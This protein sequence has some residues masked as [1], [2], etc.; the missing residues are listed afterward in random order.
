M[1]ISSSTRRSRLLLFFIC[2]LP[3]INHTSATDFMELDEVKPGMRGVGRTVFSGTKIED[4]DVEV[5]SILRN[6]SPGRNLILVRL[7]GKVVDHAGV[8]EGM[9]GS[10]VYVDGRLIGALSHALGSFMKEAI[11]GVTPIE[12]MLLLFESGGERGSIGSSS[13]GL[14]QIQVPLA[15]AG[16]HPEIVDDVREEFSELGVIPVG[17]G[18]SRS[19][20]SDPVRLEPGAMIGFSLIRGDAEMS[21]IGTVTLI[22][23]KK[24]IAFGHG[25]LHAGEVEMPLVSVYVH[26]VIPSSLLSYKLSSSSQVI[27]KLT[28]DRI[29]GVGGILGEETRLIPVTV[30]VTS[31]MLDD[32]YDYELVQYKSYTPLL[33]NWVVR[34]SVLSSSRSTGEFTIRAD[35]GIVVDGGEKVHRHTVFAGGQ[36]LNGLGRWVYQPV[37]MLLNNEFGEQKIDKITLDI[38]VKEKVDE[39]RIGSVRLNKTVLKRT[40]TL[41]VEVELVPL[42]GVSYFEKFE[43][44]LEGVAQGTPLEVSIGSSEALIAQEVERWPE[45]FLPASADHLL[46]LA[47]RSGASDELEVQVAVPDEE[48]QVEGVQLPSLPASVRRL[49]RSSKIADKTVIVRGHP[50]SSVKRRIPHSIS[51]F[52][53]VEARI[54]GAPEGPEER[55]GEEKK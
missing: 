16:L 35:M 18:I 46:Q 19:D 25:A 17:G 6:F 32:V 21:M 53:R 8:I 11:G 4:F 13:H 38:E 30:N 7:S 2:F 48:V 9:S 42:S 14:S 50:L 33:V 41:R 12:E 28:Q 22:E 43:F 47:G 45:R 24:V 3:L 34:S 37:E 15:L 10:P 49:Y 27:G 36:V 40:D 51:G 55:G 23:G 44:P 1:A 39:A 52:G 26:S 5:I 20:I 29:A 31:G 54:E